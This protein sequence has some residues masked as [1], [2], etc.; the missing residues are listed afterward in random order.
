MM[1]K[2]TSM[3][4]ANAV[5]RYV[6]IV[7]RSDSN[8]GHYFNTV[9]FSENPDEN[10]MFRTHKQFHLQYETGSRPRAEMYAHKL[11]KCLDCRVVQ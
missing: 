2:E 3:T 10:A 4:K 6:K 7:R 9:L 11:A 5:D 8:G 1:K